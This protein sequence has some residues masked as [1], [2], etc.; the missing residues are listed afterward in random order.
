MAQ[1]NYFQQRA[2]RFLAIPILLLFLILGVAPGLKAHAAEGRQSSIENLTYT[3]TSTDGASVSTKANPNETTVL[4][5]GYTTCGKTRTTLNSITS[6]EWVK[7]PDI[8]TIFIDTKG[9]TLEEVKAY[10]EGYQC[11][12]MVFCYDEGYDSF[13]AMGE[14]GRLFGINNGT[15]PTIVLIDKDNKVQNLL[16]GPQTANDVLSEIQKFA[17]IEGDGL[18]TPPSGSDT[19][20]ENIVHGLKTI[21]NTTISTKAN[22]NETTV[23]IFGYTTCGLTKETLQ[24]ISESSWVGRQDIRVIFADVYGASLDTTKAFAQTFSSNDIIFCHD[25][26]A[27]NFNLAF[28]YLGLYGQT[29]GKFPFIVLIDKNNKVQSL[30]L[31]PRTEAEVYAEI[32]KL[33]NSNPGQSPDGPGATPTPSPSPT[34]EPGPT[35][36]PT[37]DPATSVAN[38]SGLKATTTAKKVKLTW[39]K[40]PKAKGYII[41][42]YNNSKKKWVKKD[43]LKTNAASYTIQKLTPATAYRF[44][45]KAYIQAGNGTQVASKSYASIYTATAPNAVKFKVAPGK[46]KATVKWNKVKGATGY[47]VYYKAK[48]KDPWKALKSMK[49]TS[50]TK[51]KLK[52]GATY[53][54]TVKAYKTYKGATYTSSSQT[55][56]VKVK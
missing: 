3:F 26:S 27:L 41:Y 39:K 37:P 18:L 10:E 51:K 28:S 20:I 5:F 23:L 34:P 49:G 15:Y 40:V 12:E 14:Y 2:L 55:K 43:T 33:Q 45:V 31:G 24:S 38:V 29:G 17:N 19:G 53:F 44:A 48:A 32:E 11:P 42:Q 7:R 54:F 50:Y 30:T 4:I 22:A 36:T 8:R 47:T 1:N 56:K 52:S 9:H 46:K 25:E 21:E 6:C 13:A 16:T 35:I